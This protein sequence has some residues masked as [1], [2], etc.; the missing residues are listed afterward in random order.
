VRHTRILG[1]VC[2]RHPIYALNTHCCPPISIQ[3]EDLTAAGKLFKEAGLRSPFN[4]LIQGTL[5]GKL[6]PASLE[7]HRLVSLSKAVTVEHTTSRRFSKLEKRFWHFIRV[8][9]G[10]SKYRL[11]RG[12]MGAGTL[13]SKRDKMKAIGSKMNLNMPSWQATDRFAKSERPAALQYSCEGINMA[14]V[15]DLV[16]TARKRAD[17][18][19]KHEDPVLLFMSA[20]DT[21]LGK[22]PPKIVMKAVP[23]SSQPWGFKFSSQLQNT[24]NWSATGFNDGHDKAVNESM[25]N[26]VVAPLLEVM[27]HE[28]AMPQNGSWLEYALTCRP[29]AEGVLAQL[30]TLLAAV[31]CTMEHK[32]SKFQETAI[33]SAM[34]RAHLAGVTFAEGAE[35]LAAGG[36][37]EAAY[38]PNQGT[39]LTII[40]SKQRSITSAIAAIKEFIVVNEG[41][42]KRE[43]QQ[44]LGEAA[45]WDTTGQQQQQ[46]QQQLGEATAWD[47]TGQQQQQQQ[48]LGEATAWENIGQQQQE[49]QQQQQELGEATAWDNTG[50]Q[51]QELG[52][53]AAWDTTG[54]QQQQ[55]QLGE[56]AAKAYHGRIMAMCAD[57]VVL[58][59]AALMPLLIPS[60]HLTLVHIEDQG[61]EDQSEVVRME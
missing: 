35:Q 43:Q 41:L 20:D 52:E 25:L 1:R 17:S 2:T 10:K 45:A 56:A 42:I 53:A 27:R 13:G 15:K 46:Q 23:D 4:G 50:Q 40:S 19:G 16:V 38:H 47:P 60:T 21:D 59:K 37:Q 8:K 24:H 54:Q 55:Q 22:T 12:G 33:A 5:S 44:Q 57:Q 58:F 31:K 6:D 30:L 26:Q 51:Q 28:R 29:H 18:L 49:R 11:L 14:L 48:E 9:I 32:T 34:V 7:G 3:T 61:H 36:F 39:E